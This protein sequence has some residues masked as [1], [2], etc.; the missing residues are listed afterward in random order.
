MNTKRI[1]I[2]GGYGSTGLPIARLL[3]ENTDVS[4]VLAG[5]NLEKADRAAVKLNAEHGENRV[6][7][8]Y[9]DASDPQG[10]CEALKGMDM[11]VVA[12][13]TADYAETVIKSALEAGVDYLDV[14]YS[15]TKMR[16]LQSMTGE[17]ER[18]GLCFI[19]DGGFH[20]GLPAAMVR[21]AADRFDSLESA[22]V[23]SVIKIDWNTLDLS[24][25]TMEEFVG[26]FMNFQTLHFKDGRWQK[27]SV[28]AMM[29]PRF[30]DF[31]RE[32][33]RQ[34]C[35]PMFLEEMRSLPKKYPSLRETGFFVGGFNWFVD[36]FLSPIILLGLKLFPHKGLRPLGRLMFWGLK[37]FSHPP[38]GTLLKLEIKAIKNNSSKSVEMLISHKDGYALTAIPVAACL[39][40]YLDGNIRK[41]GLWFQ[42]HIVEPKRFFE[43]M[44]RMGAEVQMV[45]K[46]VKNVR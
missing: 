26:E 23:G 27:V 5:R 3:L 45:E 4:I 39:M 32:F 24:P 22:N 20:P 14:Q 1:L 36:W 35:I 12:S 37:A 30:I 29:I 34:Y 17:I 40:Q 9:A 33:G 6:T 7:G 42:A 31:G 16:V 43:E 18:A 11:V 46:C 13:S 28:L 10:L 21:F 19:T 41:P 44:E 2:L 15:T 8:V 25:A 38:Y